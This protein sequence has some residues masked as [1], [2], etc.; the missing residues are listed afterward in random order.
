MKIKFE[1]NGHPIE[2]DENPRK[3]LSE[4]FHSFLHSCLFFLPVQMK[5]KKKHLRD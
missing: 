1:L 5:R 3:K 2:V 4:F